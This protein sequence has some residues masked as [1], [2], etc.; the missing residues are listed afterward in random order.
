MVKTIIKT[1]KVESDQHG[2]RTTFS[3]ERDGVAHIVKMGYKHGA[4]IPSSMTGKAWATF[5]LWNLLSA[6]D[7]AQ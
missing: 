2:T 4:K 1:L 6:M 7:G 5:A 3:M